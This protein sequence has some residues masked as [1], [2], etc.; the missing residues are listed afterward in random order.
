MAFSGYLIK[1]TAANGTV[2]EFPITYIRYETYKATPNQRMDLD[3]TRDT[4]GLLHR[5]ALQQAARE[6]ILAKEP[7]SLLP[8]LS[9]LDRIELAMLRRIPPMECRML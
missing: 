5:N 2:T 6:S 7:D 4:T 8:R 9:N 1:F 3:P